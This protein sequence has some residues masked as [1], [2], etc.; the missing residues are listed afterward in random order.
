MRYYDWYMLVISS[1]IGS[2]HLIDISKF[3]IDSVITSIKEDKSFFNILIYPLVK[4]EGTKG[5]EVVTISL[6]SYNY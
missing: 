5:N 6:L 2:K 3:L 4:Q 1:D